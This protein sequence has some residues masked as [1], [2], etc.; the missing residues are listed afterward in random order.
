MLTVVIQA[1]GRSTRLWRDKGLIPL[2]GKPM[3]EHV[4]R[5]V[6]GLGDELMITTPRPQAYDRYT[7]RLVSD[8]ELHAGPLVGLQTALQAASY[9]TVLV[10]AC[11]MP[12][13]ERRLLEHMLSVA[14]QAD[15]VVPQH[16]G[17]YEPLQAVYSRSCLPAIEKAIASGEKR[18]VSFFPGVRV[19][20]VGPPIL[21]QL[22]P[23]GLS[24][25]N[26]NTQD[27]LVRAES[28]L[29]SESSATDSPSEE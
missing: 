22:D 1:G 19:L 15:A 13:V 6:E 10:L 26:V 25:F 20:T 21:D 18:V 28:L 4:I 16:N 2:G 11:D 29:A 9:Q 23:R 14:P 27:D 17:W 7:A 24:F 12:F 8:P 5:R 3:I